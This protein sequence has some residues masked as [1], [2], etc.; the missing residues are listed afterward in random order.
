MIL[1]LLYLAVLVAGLLPR[2][3]A[4]RAL[5]ALM[6]DLPRAMIAWITPGR[7][8]LILGLT[9]VVATLVSFAR[10]DLLAFAA[11][12]M[13][14]GV[15][16][17]VTFDVASYLDAIAL[18]GLLAATVRLRAVTERL[19]RLAGRVRQGVSTRRMSARGRRTH[20]PAR[21]PAARSSDDDGGWAWSFGQA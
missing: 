17:L 6:I 7:I 14:E 13:P 1:V 5:R 3:A 9:I 15:G 8:L 2:T 21:K 11:Q 12:G 16:W 19:R 10:Q 18:A 4:G 20:R